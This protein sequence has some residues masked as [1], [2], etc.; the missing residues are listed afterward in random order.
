MLFK[1]FMQM[2]TSTNNV[3]KLIYLN[4]SPKLLVLCEQLGVPFLE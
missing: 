2:V 3:W 4:P 1:N